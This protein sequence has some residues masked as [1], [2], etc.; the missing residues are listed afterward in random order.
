MQIHGLPIEGRTE[1]AIKIIAENV[2][3]VSEVKIETKGYMFIV[4]GKAKVSLS[5]LAPLISGIISSYQGKEHWLDFSNE[6]LPH[7]CYSSGRIGHYAK[8]CD[9]IPY[10]EEFYSNNDNI[11][12]SSWLKAKANVNSPFSNTFNREVTEEIGTDEMVPKTPVNS[13]PL[14]IVVSDSNNPHNIQKNSQDERGKRKLKEG[15]C[16]Y[17]GVSQGSE[18]FSP[19]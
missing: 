12:F 14:N 15:D 13:R 9:I 5:V 18:D 19:P 3:E 6:R 16:N 17:H 11:L 8:S 1:D 10:E 7:F 2:E 4:I